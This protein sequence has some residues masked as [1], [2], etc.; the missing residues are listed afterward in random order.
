MSVK[1][2]MHLIHPYIIIIMILIIIVMKK[3][4]CRI[5]NFAVSADHRVKLKESQKRD[6]YRD[7]ARELKKK[8]KK[9]NKKQKQKTME[10]E[11]DGDI[12][13]NQ[14]IRYSH[15][16]IGKGTGSIGNKNNTTLSRS[17]RILRRVLVT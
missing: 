15:Q 7:L 17:A 9:N 3:R 5:E 4:T 10:H 13:C 16:R 6:K 11:S 8:K 12:N 14:C 2:D 1:R